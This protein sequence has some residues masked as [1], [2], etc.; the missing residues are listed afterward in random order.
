M[1]SK[2]LNKKGLN[3]YQSISPNSY[4]NALQTF[5]I[6]LKLSPRNSQTYV[7][8]ANTYYK[9]GELK[10][11]LLD[12]NKAEKLGNR[13]PE[14]YANRGS[15]KLELGYL[16]ANNDF[17]K[18]IS[19]EPRYDY[20]Y[21]NRALL[22]YTGLNKNSNLNQALLDVNSY[23]KLNNSNELKYDHL[24]DVDFSLLLRSCIK[25]K[26]NDSKG[27]IS[28]FFKT[29]DFDN[30]RRLEIKRVRGQHDIDSIDYTQ[31]RY[32]WN[33]HM[34]HEKLSDI[35]ALIDNI[36]ALTN[37]LTSDASKEYILETLEKRGECKLYLN[38]FN[39][40]I[41]DYLK[42]I[43]S[44]DLRQQKNALTKLALVYYCKGDLKNF[45]KML[46]KLLICTFE[47]KRFSHDLI[48]DKRVENLLL[49]N[50][51]LQ[52]VKKNHYSRM[53]SIKQSI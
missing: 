36:K 23:I 9:L 34:L 51:E 20:A 13:T 53:F 47:I 5:N 15:V 30:K 48:P 25:F 8:R 29:V 37:N 40:A 11:A 10:K 17:A 28:D 45:I 42:V 7:F 31:K 43:T 6:S 38:D 27:A 12:Y 4:D 24:K 3:E 39:G 33:D 1:L 32:M 44:K 52:K 35:N 14:L 49:N 41:N 21:L 26:L 19:L 18:A 2:L 22:N 16:D 46:D 50:S